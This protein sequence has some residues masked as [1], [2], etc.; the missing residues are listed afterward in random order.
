MK[1][2]RL[3]YDH[4]DAIQTIYR[5]ARIF[6]R[7]NGNPNQWKDLFPSD[8]MIRNDLDN[9][10]LYALTVDGEIKCIFAYIF[11]HDHTYDVIYDG[12][13]LDDRP[14]GVVHRIA[15]DFSM[16]GA[17][18]ICINWAYEQCHNLRIDTHRDNLP[19]QNLLHKAGFTYCG[20]IHT[21]D[22]TD[23]LAFQK[24]DKERY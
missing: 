16:K 15:S 10:N 8:E 4:Y 18:A 13:W 12:N 3:T 1:I 11:G 9:G 23:R 22:G 19:M 20:I 14:Y 7:D 24:T 5:N 17:G 2:I 6:M 21:H